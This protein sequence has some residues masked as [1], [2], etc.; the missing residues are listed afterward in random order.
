MM[1]HSPALAPPPAEQAQTA[2]WMG[3]DERN[4]FGESVLAARKALGLTQRQL[5]DAV[6][7]T[8]GSVS[9]MEKGDLDMTFDVMARV[10]R[11]LKIEVTFT[12]Q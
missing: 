6:S 3:R 1:V 4:R 9:K 11:Y 12:N 2:G 8:Q 7:L 5:A 10:A